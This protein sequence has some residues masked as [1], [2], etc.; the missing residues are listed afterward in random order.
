MKIS[1]RLI[2]LT[3]SVVCCS[4]VALAAGVSADTYSGSAP[5]YNGPI[6]VEVDWQDGRI[7][8]IRVTSHSDTPA[9]ANPAID[10]L[11][12]RVLDQQSTDIDAVSGATDTSRGL[13]RAIDQAVRRADS[14]AAE[15]TDSVE[16]STSTRHVSDG[17]YRGNFGD[18]GEAQV[19]VQFDVENGMLRNIRFRHLFYSG[20]DYLRMD[21]DHPLYPILQQ[22]EQIIGHLEGSPVTSLSA[23]WGTGDLTDDIDG[24]SGATIRGSKLYSA[25]QDAL[26]RGVYTTAAPSEQTIGQ[27]ID[28]RYRGTF[29]D[30]GEQQVSIQFDLVDNKFENL[31]FRHL[32]YGGTDYRA[33]SSDDSLYA[34][35]QQHEAILNHLDGQSTDVVTELFEPGAI[36]PDIDGFSGATVRANKV[37]SAIMNALSRSAYVPANAEDIRIEVPADGRY[38]GVFEDGGAQQISIQFFLEDGVIRN[39][40][41]RHLYYAG[42]DY[43]ALSEGDDLYPV[44]TQHDA[45]L[46]SLNGMPLQEVVK[47]HSPAELAPDVDGFSGAT[48]RGNKVFSAIMDA[49]NR[50]LY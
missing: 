25:F 34:V 16:R 8:A 13:L 3:R 48:L 37:V 21:A 20:E 15:A 7:A 36:L 50:G 39:P 10:T 47:L 38:R 22:H 42:T 41:F 29:S 11:I 6:V 14:G 44:K 12:E 43:R 46:A 17:R 24:F 28:G 27:H 49:L 40:S 35:L 2:T 19:G 9:I 45:L 1:P 23:L 4:L 18:R 33:L 5:G 31:R 26:T 32:A 30:R